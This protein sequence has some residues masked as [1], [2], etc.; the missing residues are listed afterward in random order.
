MEETL[1]TRAA[2]ASSEGEGFQSAVSH[3]SDEVSALSQRSDINDTSEINESELSEPELAASLAARDP[4]LNVMHTLYTH[5]VP[6]LQRML[7]T[8]HNCMVDDGSCVFCMDQ[9][10]H[11]GVFLD[12]LVET[13]GD[14]VVS[15]PLN[16]QRIKSD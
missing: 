9:E 6:R 12:D 13:K 4:I 14:I 7:C 5:P 1:Q 11:G 2:L 10:E 16:E 15:N 8:K 3:R